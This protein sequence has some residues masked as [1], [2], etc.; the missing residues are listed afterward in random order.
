MVRRVLIV[1]DR[2]ENEFVLKE[3]VNKIGVEETRS[4][5][6]G[7][8]ALQC[9]EDFQPDLILMDVCLPDIN[10]LE[11]GAQ[12]RELEHC[13]DT[14]LV[15]LTGYDNEEMRSRATA[16]GFDLYR[17]K[18]ASMQMLQEVFESVREKASSLN[19]EPPAANF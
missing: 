9:L 10:G 3:L 13:S 19:L 16:A 17:L 2:R 12:I 18:P 11:L 14:F 5:S 15:A 1:D 4:A 6:D 7:E 8:A